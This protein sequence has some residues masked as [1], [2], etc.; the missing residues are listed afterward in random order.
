MGG[1][2]WG[3]I[4]IV[5]GLHLGRHPDRYAVS[6][7]E[8]HPDR[9][10]VTPVERHPDRYEVSPGERQFAR[11]VVSPGAH[12]D[13]YVGRVI[14][15]VTWSHLE[16]LGDSR[17][18]PERHKRSSYTLHDFA[19]NISLIFTWS[20]LKRHPDRYVVSPIASPKSLRGLTCGASS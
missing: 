20:H 16:V 3:V 12:P 7:A 14:L 2:A 18:G 6:P 5:A 1:L 19:G 9:Y 10:A 4:L 8:H 15:I 11:Y 17:S 13:R